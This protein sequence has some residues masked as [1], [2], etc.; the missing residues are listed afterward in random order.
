MLS[1]GL[2]KLLRQQDITWNSILK[3]HTGITTPITV[4]ILAVRW[5]GVKCWWKCRSIKDTLYG[6]CYP[7]QS[8]DTHRAYGTRWRDEMCM[9]VEHI[10]V[11]TDVKSTEQSFEEDIWDKD[12][13]SEWWDVHDI[14]DT[15]EQR[16]F[17][18]M[19][20]ARQ[21]ARNAKETWS[22][23]LEE[24]KLLKELWLRRV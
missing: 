15:M 14:K 20:H 4:T 17:K 3:K 16:M 6:G 1:T 7:Y 22:R 8:D 23:W 2:N 9:Y 10:G 18:S 12:Q 11:M 19:G 24:K 5:Y 13:T 21:G